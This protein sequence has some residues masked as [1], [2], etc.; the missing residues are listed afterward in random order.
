MNN[1]NINK[2]EKS[3]IGLLNLKSSFK[4]ISFSKSFKKFN[5]KH[6]ETILLI[7]II[8]I[9][10]SNEYIK[11]KSIKICLCCIGKNENLYAREFVE[12]YKRIGYD[13]IF[14]YDNNEKKGERFEEVINDYIKSGFVKII[15]YRER[16]VNSRP[17]FDA[18]KDCYERNNKLYNWLSFFDMDEFLEINPKYK[19][20]HDFLKD[21]IFGKCQNIKINWVMY[22][23]YN[24]LYYENKSISERMKNCGC[25]ISE[26]VHIKSTVKG[27]LFQNYWA[28]I[29]NPH[30]STLKVTSCSSSGK[31]ISHNSPFNNPP[32]L[33]NARL[34][35]YHYKSFEEYCLKLQRGNADLHKNTNIELV[36]RRYE[37][38]YSKNKN[39]KEKLEIINKIF[40]N[41]NNYSKYLFNSYNKK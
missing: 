24:N 41:S 39:S 4:D 36:N 33:T 8:G 38:L 12:H 32:D 28:N 25:N 34:N 16:N 26:N 27:N 30:S 2:K 10:F 23:N 20:I 14:I 19:S 13:N 40:N 6:K 35:H 21:K 7:L 17:Q 3:K 22:L 5:K 37:L 18:Y 15:D 9:F 29:P 11:K 1:Q 31:I